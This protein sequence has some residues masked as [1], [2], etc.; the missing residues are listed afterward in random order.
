MWLL[1]L[2]LLV[3]VRIVRGGRTNSDSDRSYIG[4]SLDLKQ[5]KRV[6]SLVCAKS[7]FFKLI[8]FNFPTIFLE[9]Q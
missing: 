3:F 4:F 7:K 1:E 6:G 5:K 2:K 9:P 8:S